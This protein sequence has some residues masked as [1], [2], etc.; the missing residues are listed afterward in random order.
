MNYYKILEIEENADQNQIKK[1]FRKAALVNHPDRGG[2][3]ETF[4]KYQKAY[5]ILSDPKKKDIYDRLLLV[6]NNV[7]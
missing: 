6:R 5:E 2:N 3:E 7:F 1:A 4:K